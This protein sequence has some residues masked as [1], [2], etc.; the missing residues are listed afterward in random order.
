V[1]L[2]TTLSIAIPSVLVLILA[3]VL[4]I[5]FCKFKCCDK[6]REK[7]RDLSKVI[8]FNLMIRSL[9]AVYINLCITT[10]L[11]IFSEGKV[12]GSN[13]G[14]AIFLVATCLSSLLFALV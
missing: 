3:I 5:K 6:I 4:A 7:L 12:T 10:F 1:N 9:L 11:G 13:I 2:A 14:M 8:F